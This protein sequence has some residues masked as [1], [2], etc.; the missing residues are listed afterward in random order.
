MAVTMP[1]DQLLVEDLIAEVDAF[2]ADVDPRPS[3]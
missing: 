3:D 2:I 1:I